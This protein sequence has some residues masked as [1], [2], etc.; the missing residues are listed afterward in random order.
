M[1]ALL[2]LN[3]NTEIQI[4]LVVHIRGMRV[5]SLRQKVNTLLLKNMDYIYRNRAIKGVDSRFISLITFVLAAVLSSCFLL[6]WRLCCRV[7]YFSTGGCVGELF[8]FVLAAVLS[9][10]FLLY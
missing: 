3:I 7:V 9:S 2:I 5:S 8:P 1:Y 6:Y 4:V 10:C